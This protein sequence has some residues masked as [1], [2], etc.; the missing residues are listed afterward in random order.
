[1]ITG[2]PEE[3][4]ADQDSTL[5]LIGQLLEIDPWKVLVQLHVL[6]PEPGSELAERSEAI[7]FDGVGP[8]A[9]DLVDAELVSRHPNIFSVFYH[10]EAG[11]PRWR[12]VYASAFV[13]YLLPDL[14]TPLVT[15][16]RRGLFG[17]RLAGLFSAI[18]PERPDAAMQYDEIVRVLWA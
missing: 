5:D 10:F 2:F 12:T 13:T 17:G 8:E 16:L 14:G 3:T 11:P 15:F 6:S 9:D 4:E 18:V 1:M 7:A